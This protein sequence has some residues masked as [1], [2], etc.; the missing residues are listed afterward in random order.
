MAI[1]HV[2]IRRVTRV[3]AR[4]NADDPAEAIL[5]D[6]FVLWRAF[7]ATWEP[8]QTE[9]NAAK[10]A[11]TETIA[12]HGLAALTSLRNWLRQLIHLETAHDKDLRQWLGGK[13]EPTRYQIERIRERLEA[14]LTVADRP[15]LWQRSHSGQVGLLLYDMRCAV[16]HPRLDTQHALAQRILPSLREA[17]VELVVARAAARARMS[18]PESKRLFGIT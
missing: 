6:V 1:P 7:E 8:S 2:L 18:V 9:L 10:Q 5:D 13:D 11:V 15:E 3:L 17:L 14:V 16:I 12:F 4:A